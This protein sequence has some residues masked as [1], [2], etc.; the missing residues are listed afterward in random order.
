MFFFLVL[1][2]ALSIAVPGIL[3][4]VCVTV[5]V[6]TSSCRMCKKWKQRTVKTGIIYIL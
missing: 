6:T 4:F 2:I 3:L 5:I 1:S